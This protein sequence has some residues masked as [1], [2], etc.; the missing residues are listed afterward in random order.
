MADFDGAEP[1]SS[2]RGKKPQRKSHRPTGGEGLHPGTAKY[3]AA[4]IP[5][6]TTRKR[7]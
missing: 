7:A 4:T 6:L 5:P 1:I 3:R 2:V